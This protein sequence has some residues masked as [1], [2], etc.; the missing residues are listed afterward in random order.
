M[1]IF[2]RYCLGDVY[3]PH[4]HTK[5]RSAHEHWDGTPF[6]HVQTACPPLPNMPFQILIWMGGGNRQL[7][8]GVAR[9]GGKRA[10]ALPFGPPRG[11]KEQQDYKKFV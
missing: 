11:A 1:C 9:G 3:R 8:S 6:G 7:P 4:L 2:I 5:L 10:K